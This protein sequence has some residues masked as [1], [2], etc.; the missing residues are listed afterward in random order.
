MRMM[1]PGHR[2]IHVAFQT[3]LL[4][5]MQMSIPKCHNLSSEHPKRLS[6]EF[7]RALRPLKLR[8]LRVV[9][10]FRTVEEVF[11]SDAAPV[12]H[13]PKDAALVVEIDGRVE[14]G[15]VSSVHD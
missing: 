7:D 5:F 13:T 12:A 11:A 10:R 8:I 3:P 14:L 6:F 2:G 1:Y 4:C 9:S 15:Y